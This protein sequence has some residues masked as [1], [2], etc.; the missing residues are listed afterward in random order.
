MAA[1]TKRFVDAASAGEPSVTCW[2]TGAPRREFLHVD[3]LARG[4]MLLLANNPYGSEPVN[5]GYGSDVT[6]RELA[7][8]IAR[9]AGFGGD[10]LWDSSKPDGM[11]K[12]LMDP[13]RARAIGFAPEISLE[14]GVE[15]FVALYR[16][17]AGRKGK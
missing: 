14:N 5:I 3:D 16:E 7:F 4:I 11:M 9:S 2:G 13:A 1:L 10:I 12:K 6:I 15:S 8:I 17:A